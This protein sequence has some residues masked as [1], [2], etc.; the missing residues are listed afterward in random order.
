M[1]GEVEKLA[2]YAGQSSGLIRS[3]QP[4]AEIVREITREA[5][6]TLRGVSKFL[7]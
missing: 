3:I 5:E 1:T 2:L 4:A 7:E 6:K